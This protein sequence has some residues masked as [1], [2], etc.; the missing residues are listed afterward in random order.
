MN[1]G[2]FED[3]QE[4]T[5][6]VGDDILRETIKKAEADQFSPKSWS[7]WHYRLRLAEVDKVPPLRVRRF[8]LVEWASHN[9]LLMGYCK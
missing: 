8:H 6:Q 4:L 5:N 3:V 2:D 1:I 9:I 7:Y